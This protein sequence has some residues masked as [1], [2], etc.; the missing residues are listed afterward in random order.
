MRFCALFIFLLGFL[1]L[2]YSFFILLRKESKGLTSSI[3][4]VIGKLT[5][6]FSPTC[7]FKSL[8]YCIRV[9]VSFDNLFN[10]IDEILL[11]N[12]FV[13]FVK[14]QWRIRDIRLKNFA[15]IILNEIVKVFEGK[16]NKFHEFVLS[17]SFFPKNPN[18]FKRAKANFKKKEAQ[19]CWRNSGLLCFVNRIF[20]CCSRVLID[21][22]EPSVKDYISELKKVLGDNEISCIV[23]THWHEDHVGGISD[24]IKKVVS[25]TCKPHGLW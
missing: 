16:H 5:I 21:T 9:A 23:C 13:D 11:V 6:F 22:G 15:S 7:F 4:C 25:F 17:K 19:M 24:V 8:L 10:D 3:L 18:F 20:C 12:A 1:K 14:L 2:I